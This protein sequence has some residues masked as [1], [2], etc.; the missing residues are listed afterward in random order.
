MDWYFYV[1]L[2]NLLE[3]PFTRIVNY[4]EDISKASFTAIIRIGNGLPFVIGAKM[5]DKIKF[6]AGR[7][8]R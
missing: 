3:E 6:W 4:V 8:E 1:C 7:G 2:E 5:G